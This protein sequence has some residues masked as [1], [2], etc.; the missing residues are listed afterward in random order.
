MYLLLL[1][2][3]GSIL[4]LS[5]FNIFP[6]RFLCVVVLILQRG[7]SAGLHRA[8]REHLAA[9]SASLPHSQLNKPLH[10]NKHI[11]KRNITKKRG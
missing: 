7:H 9:L 3:L 2:S 11:V 8:R 1:L 10:P 4:L 5:I 6:L